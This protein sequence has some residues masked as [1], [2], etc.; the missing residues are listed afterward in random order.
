MV[1]TEPG[2]LEHG[3][4]LVKP[5]RKCPTPGLPASL[6]EAMAPANCSGQSRTCF[7]AELEHIC[8]AGPMMACQ[9]F[10]G[11]LPCCGVGA[12]TQC[13]F[14]PNLGTLHHLSAFRQHGSPSDPT[15]HLKLNLVHLQE[16]AQ[17]GPIASGLQPVVQ[18]C[19]AGICTW[20]LNGGGDHTFRNMR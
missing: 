6:R 16:G 19:Q 9:P 7:P 5:G 18:E 8:P 3:S 15:M 11:L 10:P 1:G 20:Q 13:N 12:C 17:V 14:L 4:A 2:I